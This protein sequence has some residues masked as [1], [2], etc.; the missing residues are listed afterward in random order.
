[1]VT[2]SNVIPIKPAKEK[3]FK[4]PKALGQ[5]ADLLYETRQARLDL[6]KAVEELQKQ[7]TLLKEHFINTLPISQA[8]GVSGKAGVVK[9]VPKEVYQVKDWDLFYKHVKRTGDFDLLQR[10]LADAA[11]KERLEAGKTVPGIEKFMT[12]TVS[13]TKA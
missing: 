3:E 9:V 11:Y 10:R 6:Q 2:K 4:I 7:E 8:S 5:A 1:M 13:I 12:K